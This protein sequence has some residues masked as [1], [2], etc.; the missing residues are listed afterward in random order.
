[1]KIAICHR[2][3]SFS[4]R[5]IEYCQKNNVK[6][7][8]VDAFNSDIIKHVND[9][10]VFM[11]HHHHA[12]NKDI[13]NAKRILFTLEQAGLIV[14]PNFNTGWHFDDK[15]AQ[16][17]LLEALNAPLVK[18]YVFYSKK[19]ALNWAKNTTYPKV[20]KLK[21]GAG[22]S[23]VKLVKDYKKAVLLINKSFGR[24][25]KLIDNTYNFKEKFKKFK[26]GKESFIN[27]IK[28]II[29]SILYNRI[30][31]KMIERNYI[32]FQD[33]IPNN[34]SDTRVIVIGEKAFAI[35]RIVREN[36]FRASGSGNI[37]YNYK[38]INS[39]CIRVAFEINEKI[40]SQ[41][42]AFDFII[43]SSGKPLIVEISYGF[44]MKAYDKCPGYWNTNLDWIDGEISPQ[45]WII[46]NIINQTKLNY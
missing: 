29:T 4:D 13:I 43:D 14:F 32:Y 20:F 3:G 10:D 11:W 36:D 35:K 30:N 7:K 15:V 24:G 17:Y 23:N 26:S 18:S 34:D 27:V 40:K 45:F 22:A 44:S 5:W 39:E 21:G 42:N 33:F 41:C 31:N 28:S 38:E 6:Y 46:E 2:E 25:F 19:E 1:M 12:N 37:V 9:C 8:I 16:K